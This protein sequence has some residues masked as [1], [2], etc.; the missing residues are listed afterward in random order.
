MVL[1]ISFGLPI[2][3]QQPIQD[4]PCYL[5]LSASCLMVKCCIHLI[6][7]R[8]VT[9]LPRGVVWL[10]PHSRMKHERKKEKKCI[11]KKNVAKTWPSDDVCRAIT[12]PSNIVHLMGDERKEAMRVN[13]V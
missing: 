8:A 5:Y 6:D 7:C 4:S 13:V 9:W 10:P 12:W 2:A 3:T 11:L 1:L